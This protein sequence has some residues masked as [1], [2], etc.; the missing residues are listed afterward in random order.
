MMISPARLREGTRSGQLPRVEQTRELFKEAF[1]DG[2]RKRWR[3]NHSPSSSTSSRASRTF[4]APPGVFPVTPSLAAAPCYLM[5]MATRPAIKS[6]RDHRL[7]GLRSRTRRAMREL[8]GAL[9]LRTD[10]RDRHHGLSSR[11]DSRDAGHALV[12][13][14]QRYASFREHRVFP[15]GV[16]GALVTP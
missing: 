12:P 8:H 15:Y 14:V 10:G 16:C 7:V 6:G 11:V 13:R 2:H 9:R 5:A 3:L 1:A 4:N